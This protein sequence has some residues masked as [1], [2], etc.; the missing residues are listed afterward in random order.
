MKTLIRAGALLALASLV[1][2]CVTPPPA[3]DYT[4]YR[5]ARPASILILPPLN[6]TPE[7]K[8]T[9]GML[10]QMTAPLAEAGYY[11]LPVALVDE[12]FRQNGLSN[13]AEIHQVAPA[14]LREI[15]GADSALY[16]TVVQYGSTYTLIDSSVRVEAKANLVDLR[17]GKLLWSGSALATDQNN[18]SGGGL[19]GMLI[20]AAVKQVMNTL[21]DA[22]YP[23]AGMASG[24]L[25]S[26]GRTN[27]IL[28][29][30][31]S[32]QYGLK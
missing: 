28:H 2:G 7:V 20:T 8:A 22:T 29:G 30:P 12:T 13:A 14:K 24:Q 15:F 27:G 6:E 4:A 16:V 19:V 21:T 32:P 18:N 9:Y 1:T 3:Y 23:V 25:L 26:A 10:S 11:V 31:R 5:E 17:T